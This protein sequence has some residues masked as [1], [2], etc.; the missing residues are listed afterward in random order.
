PYGPSMSDVVLATLRYQNLE[1][2]DYTK[3]IQ[4][5]HSRNLLPRAFGITGMWQQFS[6]GGLQDDRQF[7]ASRYLQVGA[8][9]EWIVMAWASWSLPDLVYQTDAVA[10]LRLRVNILTD[11]LR[12]RLTDTIHRNYGELQRV[13]ARLAQ[14]GIDL[15]TKLVY[16]ARA[17]Q[18]E[19]VVDLASG[20]YLTRWQKKHRR[21][22]P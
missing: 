3:R 1:L 18:L 7:A 12:H 11:E 14:G 5:A 4:R 15:K 13:Q 22:A 16:L 19:A 9:D 20:G 2:A 17:E 21:N 6:I 10:L 8:A